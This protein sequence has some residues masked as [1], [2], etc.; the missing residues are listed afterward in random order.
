MLSSFNSYA[1]NRV[2]SGDIFW[3]GREIN[4]HLGY[5]VYLKLHIW[6]EPR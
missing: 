4:E 1:V 6:A 2:N 3:G 5:I